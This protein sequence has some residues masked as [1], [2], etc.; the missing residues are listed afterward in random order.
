MNRTIIWPSGLIAVTL[1]LLVSLAAKAQSVVINTT[2]SGTP[3]SLEGVWA[4]PGC[5]PSDPPEPGETDVLE[6]FIFRGDRFEVR[7]LQYASNDG[8]CAGHAMSLSSETGTVSIIGEKQNLGWIDDDIPLRQDGAGPLNATPVVTV[9]EYAVDDGSIAGDVYY[10]DVTAEPWCI[11]REVEFGL[12]GAEEPLCK[13]NIELPPL[14]KCDIR[15]NQLAFV[16]GET[17]TADVFRLANSAANPVATEIKLWL[18]VPGIAP[19]SILNLG[20][21]GGLVLPAGA[22]IDLGPMPLFPVT[23]ALPRGTYEFSC[24]MLDPMTGEFLAL[25]RESFDIE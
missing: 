14:P 22:D 4:F 5:D 15:L 13:V 19:V 25:D 17:V 2:E 3:R 7:E 23:T 24:R 16:D 12:M 18:V 9:L 21:Y 8:S 10:M 6:V 20:S 1:L 11:Y